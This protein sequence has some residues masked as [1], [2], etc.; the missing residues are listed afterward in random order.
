MTTHAAMSGTTREDTMSTRRTPTEMA[1]AALDTA[2]RKV[3]R[4]DARVQRAAVER[5]D[6][7]AAL[8]RAMVE[9]DYAAA[10]PLLRAVETAEAEGVTA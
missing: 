1:Q 8:A 7:F 9:R 6:A 3:E 5:D 4:A 10:H 2:Q